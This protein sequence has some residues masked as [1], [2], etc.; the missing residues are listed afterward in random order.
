[1]EDTTTTVASAGWY[2]WQGAVIEVIRQQFNGLFAT[3][4]LDDVDWPEWRWLFERGL[5]PQT[6][7]SE[8][9]LIDL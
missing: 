4:G 6:A 5:S 8:A 2:Q 3:I 7:V 1:M 9:F